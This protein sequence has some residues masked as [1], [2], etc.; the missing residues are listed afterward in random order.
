VVLSPVAEH[1]R[2]PDEI[3]GRIERLVAG[4][5]L[6]LFGREQVPG[7]TVWGNEIPSPVV[8]PVNDGLDIPE[9]FD[10]RRRAAP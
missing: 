4:P 7:W 8:V 10:R 1:S 5:Y 2:K 3:L 9:I 6:E